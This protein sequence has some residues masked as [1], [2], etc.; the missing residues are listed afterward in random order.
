MIQKSE[1]RICEQRVNLFFST[2]S[3]FHQGSRKETHRT[4]DRFNVDP[5]KTREKLSH[6]KIA[7]R[8]LL[9]HLLHERGLNPDISQITIGRYGKPKL[10]K[11][12]FEFNISH[13]SDLVVLAMHETFPVGVDVMKR[14][15]V[16][17]DNDVIRVFS[18]KSEWTSLCRGPAGGQLENSLRLFTAK[19]AAVKA[20]GTGF[21]A[22]PCKLEFGKYPKKN[23]VSKIEFQGKTIVVASDVKW[24][25]PEYLLSCALDLTCE[26]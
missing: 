26:K 15:N 16:N 8:V 13:D 1:I 2:I 7:G 24:S 21:H 18:T 6:Q 12:N 5:N 23:S 22:D 10:A 4:N 11:Q 20:I 17:F 14:G 3:D 19:E 9:N 25:Q